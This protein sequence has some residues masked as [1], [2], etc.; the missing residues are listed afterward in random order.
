MN[1][2]YCDESDKEI[3]RIQTKKLNIESQVD[4]NRASLTK[5][6]GCILAFKGGQTATNIVEMF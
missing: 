4:K 3:W 1:K 6:K 2:M 5:E